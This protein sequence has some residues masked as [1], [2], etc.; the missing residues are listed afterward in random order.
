METLN[1]TKNNSVVIGGP[2]MSGNFV[3]ERQ[4]IVSKF[5]DI[6]GPPMVWSA[7]WEIT[8]INNLISLQN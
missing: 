6:F 8:A 2:K 4:R 1:N 7:C 5:P 3:R